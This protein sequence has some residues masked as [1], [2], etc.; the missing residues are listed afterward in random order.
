[1]AKNKVSALNFTI[2]APEWRSVALLLELSS[3]WGQFT[4]TCV[5]HFALLCQ[6]QKKCVGITAWLK[7]LSS[8]FSLSRCKSWATSSA[9]SEPRWRGRCFTRPTPELPTTTAARRRWLL[10]ESRDSPTSCSR[11]CCTRVRHRGSRPHGELLEEGP[12]TNQL[13]LRESNIIRSIGIHW[14]HQSGI[15][16][17]PDVD[18]PGSTDAIADAKHKM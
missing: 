12:L 18:G 9:G 4:I 13:A 8:T 14:V 5:S 7:F 15:I 2:L 10:P 11:S 16:K 6:M 1:M 3:K 17:A